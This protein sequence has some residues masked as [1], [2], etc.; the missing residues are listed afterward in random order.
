MLDKA[1]GPRADVLAPLAAQKKDVEGGKL[2]WPERE[3]VL[4]SLPHM[5]H[6]LAHRGHA[7][8]IHGAGGADDP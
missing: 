6:E 7:A 2:E 8:K 3:I 4:V 1:L 5:V